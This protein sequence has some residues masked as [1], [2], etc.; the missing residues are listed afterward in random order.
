M[1]LVEAF[2][3]ECQCGGYALSIIGT[4]VLCRKPNT[5]STRNTARALPWSS[6]VPTTVIGKQ[7]EQL[8]WKKARVETLALQ[9]QLLA[10]E[11]RGANWGYVGSGG[12]TAV[13]D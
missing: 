1:R 4:A 7:G 10:S 8:D 9:A 11:L 3:P 12:H 2:Q 5:P 13:W 6:A